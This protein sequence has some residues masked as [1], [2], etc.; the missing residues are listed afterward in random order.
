MLKHIFFS[1]FLVGLS[2]VALA[3]TARVLSLV[4]GVESSLAGKT[5][6]LAMKMDIPVKSSVK[7]DATGKAQFMFPDGSTIS[8]APDTEIALSEFVETPEQEKIILNL[9]KGTARIITGEVSRKNPAAFTIKTPQAYIGIRGTIV[10]ITVKGDETKIYLT[11][12]S[13]KGVSVKNRATGKTMELRAPG[14]IILVSP[15]G[16]EQRKPVKGEVLAI[17]SSIKTVAA[18]VAV[19]TRQSLIATNSVLNKQGVAERDQKLVAELR[20]PSSAAIVR[21]STLQ[22][23]PISPVAP[24][25]PDPTTVVPTPPVAPTPVDPTPVDP[26]SIPQIPGLDDPNKPI[27]STDPGGI[28]N[29]GGAPTDILAQQGLNLNNMGG[30]YRIE[31][32]DL[33]AYVRHFGLDGDL[34]ITTNGGILRMIN[35]N[36]PNFNISIEGKLNYIEKMDNEPYRTRFDIPFNLNSNFEVTGKQ[37]NITTTP[38]WDYSRATGSHVEMNIEKCLVNPVFTNI[39]VNF[40]SE[41]SGNVKYEAIKPELFISKD[42]LNYHAYETN[43]TVNFSK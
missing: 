16:I 31:K 37:I 43:Q 33:L 17:T 39:Q 1:I 41:N 35:P 2:S 26:P 32:I 18:P 28:D 22:T 29:I 20:A 19:S 5:T 10:S 36:T 21:K 25:P 38:Q 14:N 11:E 23:S 7:S 6:A 40:T 8:V 3:N 30:E 27:Y 4:P 13:G 42:L 12:T 9:A 24:T 34:N 15:Q